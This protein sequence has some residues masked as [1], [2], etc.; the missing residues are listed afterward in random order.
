[1]AKKT[2]KKTLAPKK[3]PKPNLTAATPR[4]VRPG[5]YESFR[6]HKPIAKRMPEMA[7]AFRLLFRAIKLL[8]SNWKL[9]GGII[10]IYLI[11]ELVLVQ[12][13][14]LL[15][16]GNSLGTTKHLIS[17]AS[18]VA[19][20]STSLFLLLVGNGT[21]NTSSSAY[22]FVLLLLLSLVLIWTIRQH[23]LGAVVRIRDGFYKG[24]GQLVPFILVLLSIGAEL[25]PGALGIILYTA[26]TTNGI[27]STM[28][29]HVLWGL[30]TVIL[31]SVS[32]YL[33]AGSIF[34]LY[35]VTLN[36]M[37]PVRALR[38][39]SK[40]VHNRRLLVIRK[41]I[42]LPI[43]IFIIMAILVV[44]FLLF[45]VKVAPAVFFIV[46]ALMVALLHTYLYG[47][48]RELLNE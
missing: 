44:P 33:V 23:Y 9:F 6:L 8:C 7:G 5:K 38:M 4:Q 19:T 41:I 46:T 16:S 3:A 36:D 40:L 15:T 43:A 31:I 12:G 18:N 21:G 42:F 24:L 10:L 20:T 30:I 1:M 47:L 14:S 34:A 39:A 26:V 28:V 17:G 25:I 48:Y 13:L 35:I 32:C 27:A 29:E 45:A 22:Q 11:L 2:P 37:T